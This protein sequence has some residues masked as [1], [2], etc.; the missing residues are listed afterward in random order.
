MRADANNAPVRATGR[1]QPSIRAIRRVLSSL[2]MVAAA[3]AAAAVVGAQPT[4]AVTK[5]T[6]FH[7]E[8]SVSTVIHASDATVW[9]ILTSADDY[10]RWNTTIT[11]IRG[12][13]A[14]HERIV[15]RS[16]LDAKRAFTLTVRE[17]TPS[18]RL[19]WGDRQGARTYEIVRISDSTVTFHMRERIGGAMFPLYAR[20]IP[21]FDTS[22]NAFAADLKRE[23]ERVTALHR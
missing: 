8:T 13:I 21:S 2:S 10:P 16:T 19:V 1:P 12:R 23:A 7:R 20:A 17:F 5:R 11:S 14:L 6:T 15:L 22:F 3:A 18:S 9:A 4:A